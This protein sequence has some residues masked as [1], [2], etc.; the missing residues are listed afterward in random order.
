MQQQSIFKACFFFLN[1][2]TVTQEKKNKA[3][4]RN[5][6]ALKTRTAPPTF[7]SGRSGYP[8][9]VEAIW[10]SMDVWMFDCP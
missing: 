3:H 1:N 7:T 10:L 5:K 2:I 8:R 4:Q 9:L 6:H